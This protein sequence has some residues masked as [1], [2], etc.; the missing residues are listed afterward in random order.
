MADEEEKRPLR[1]LRFREFENVAGDMTADEIRRHYAKEMLELRN[2]Y[3]GKQKS[4]E[5]LKQAKE[6]EKNDIAEQK[7]DIGK[8]P[9]KFYDNMKQRYNNEMSELAS[10]YPDKGNPEYLRR[11]AQIEARFAQFLDKELLDS[12]QGAYVNKVMDAIELNET[13]IGQELQEAE[14]QTKK[15]CDKLKNSAQKTNEQ[16]QLLEANPDM[17]TK[18]YNV[19]QRSSLPEYK[20]KEAVQIIS[21]PKGQPCLSVILADAQIPTAFSI[22]DGKINFQQE[23]I[24]KMTVDTMRRI[25][26][27]LER[28]GIH[29][30]ELPDGIDEKLA[31]AYNEADK[32]NREAEEAARIN[33]QESSEAKNA[34]IQPMPENDGSK[35]V[36][37][38]GYTNQD[39][40]DFADAFGNNE[41]VIAA[42]TVDYSKAYT[43][44]DDWVFGAGGMNK[45]KNWTAFKSYKTDGGWDS[46]AIYDQGNFKNEELDGKVDKDGYMKVKYAFKIYSRVKK[47]NGSN[48]LEVRYAMPNG[49]KITDDYAEGLMKVM[50]KTGVTH[51]NFPDGLPETDGGAFRIGCAKNGLVPLLKNLDDTKV[52]KM[53]EAAETRLSAKELVDYKL[54]LAEWMEE[55]AIEDCAKDGKDFDQHKNATLINNLKAEYEYAPFRDMYE[56]GGGIRKVLED[57]VKANEENDKDGLAVVVGASNAAKDLF[58][59]YKTHS[60]ESADAVIIALSKRLN[61]DDN[62]IDAEKIKQDFLRSMS[63]DEKLAGKSFDFGK[64][65]RDMSPNEVGALMRAILP[66]E[67]K[68][69]QKKIEEKF[70]KS[71]ETTNAGGVGDKESTITSD[72]RRIARD[73]IS[74]IDGELKDAGIK[75]IYVVP[76]GYAEYDYSELRKKYP[77]K[78]GRGSDPHQYD[79]D[80][81]DR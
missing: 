51:V 74:N 16:Q 26:D 23:I 47:V 64:S 48:R 71:I 53:L 18:L 72:M 57:T 80:E 19:K 1:H 6:A 32:A 52:K 39:A 56:K 29:G 15:E 13:K 10:E 9:Q 17:Y 8:D 28:R 22:S 33:E 25:V 58:E 81:N 43:S 61:K 36:R 34:P 70:R 62:P 30:I 78:K 41:T 2:D 14:I 4:L 67:E 49:K 55:C 77:K 21:G 54:R 45:Q 75:G 40:R 24:D 68:L 63:K 69:A 79:D 76:V 11:A 46:W 65:F 50:K 60:T 35:E 59:V 42:Q 31:A 27:Y 73:N 38:S 37:A 12:N 3:Q 66:Q 5:N 7:V 20:G 44:I